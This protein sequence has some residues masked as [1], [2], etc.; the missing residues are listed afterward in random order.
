MYFYIIST[1]ILLAAAIILEII[2]KEKLFHNFKERIIWVAVFV[3]IGT[4]WDTWA[5]INSH[6]VFTGRGILGIYIGVIPLEE[7][8]WYL[9]V[10]YFAITVYKTI[11]II[12]DSK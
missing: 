11:H 5:L 6:W 10:P 4:V 7:F 9:V 2:F 3:L 1:G 8:I 12:S